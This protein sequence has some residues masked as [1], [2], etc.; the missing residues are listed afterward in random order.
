MVEFRSTAKGV[1]FAV[2]VQP[3]ASRSELV[4]EHGDTLRIRIAAPP[5]DGAANDELTR[6][7]AKALHV[8]AADVHVVAGQTGK[9]KLIEITGVTVPQVRAALL[10]S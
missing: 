9:R 8:P 1:R 2:T 10:P 4:G 6:F 3:R 5:V 7:L